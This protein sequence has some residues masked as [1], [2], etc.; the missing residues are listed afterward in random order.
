MEHQGLDLIRKKSG[1]KMT[2]N[3]EQRNL[4]PE[5]IY[6]KLDAAE[7][8]VLAGQVIDAEKG[9]QHIRDKYKSVSYTHLDVY[10]RQAVF[11]FP[12]NRG[13]DCRG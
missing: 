7:R 8:Q 12:F 11:L 6:Q 3:S 1:D 2:I 10:K 4:L 13:K 5:G 9:L